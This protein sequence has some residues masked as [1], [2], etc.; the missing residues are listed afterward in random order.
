MG[1]RSQIYVRFENEKNKKELVARYYSW[2]YGERMISRA[3]H[4]IEW[5]EEES[6]RFYWREKLPRILDINF[7]MKDVVI[8]SDIIEEYADDIEAWDCTL[9]EFFESQDNNNG[10]LLIDVVSDSIKYAFLNWENKYLGDGT[11]YMKEEMADW[12]ENGPDDYH[13]QEDIDTCLNNIQWLKDNATLMTEE[14][15]DEYL[16]HDYNWHLE[17]YRPKNP[18]FML[19]SVCEREILTEKFMTLQDAKNQMIKEFDT[20][21]EDAHKDRDSLIAD[22]L[23]EIC[24]ENAWI[25]DLRG[26]NYDW[27]IVAMR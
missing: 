24:D 5:L 15:A 18:Q 14:E 12:L 4:S 10:V 11:A 26:N 22:D 8:S 9:N 7:D 16:Q 20:A 27:Q 3:R 23:A 1:Q 19:L 6:S 21:I 13:D 25:N 2:N 17:N